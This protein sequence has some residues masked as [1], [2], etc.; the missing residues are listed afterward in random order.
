MKKSTAYILHYVLQRKKTAL[1]LL[2]TGLILTG[3][4]I[5]E[6]ILAGEIINTALYG[7]SSDRL[8]FLSLIW[9]VIF[10]LK[11]A[12]KY[13]KERAE[14]FLTLHT[15]HSIQHDL[16]Q[17]ILS[18]PLSWFQKR[19]SGYIAA[20]QNSDVFNLE[21]MLAPRL[22]SGLLASAE[23]VVIAVLLMNIHFWLGL[24]ALTLKGMD[25]FFNFCFP[26]KQI[27]KA[28]QESAAAAAAEMQDILSGIWLVKAAGREAQELQRYDSFLRKTYNTWNKRDNINAFRR[29]ITGFSNDASYMIMII[30]GGI[31]MTRGYMTA[32]DV[33][34]FLLYFQKLSGA[35]QNAIPLIPLFKIAQASTERLYEFKESARLEETSSLRRTAGE[36]AQVLP[37][38]KSISFRNVSFAYGAHS[39]LNDLSLTFSKGKI[40]AIAGRSGVGKSTMAA[41]LLGIIHAD[42]GSIIIDG[43]D[44]RTISP[45]LLRRAII[46]LPQEPILFH[47]SLRE[48]LTYQSAWPGR[49]HDTA[50]QQA[51]CASHAEEIVQTLP[52]GLDT[53]LT[54]K[55]ETLSGGEKQRL[56]IARAL[57]ADGDV[58]VLDESTSAI[59]S[60]SEKIIQDTLRKLAKT[61]IVI[62][63]AHRLSTIQ[64][65]DHI[66]VL[67]HGHVAEEGN[68]PSLMRKKGLYWEL[69]S[70]QEKQRKV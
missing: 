62:V 35:L 61:K 31:S 12:A 33:M 40:T 42:K 6:P 19:T 44:I 43:W 46:V 70:Q 37:V 20:R 24:A 55:G 16:F 30:C 54:E 2:C 29:L 69:F 32:G 36:H 52:H 59:D 41:L 3:V 7:Q 38:W 11:Y 34:T 15:M 50:T 58:L 51:L 64:Q 26:L 22:I 8:L 18:A 25:L 53:V 60:L 4:N 63:I 23:I 9:C 49:I 67:D 21:G 66:Y 13:I 17:V 27:Y 10:L 65:A 14:I 57:L 45:S 68:H 28:Y 39:V 48:N 5:W 56:S 47:R 1:L